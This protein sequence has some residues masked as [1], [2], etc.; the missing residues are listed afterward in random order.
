MS[1]ETMSQAEYDHHVS[2]VWKT[3]GILAVVTIIEVV[4][5]LVY[6]ES[7]PRMALNLFFIVM[8]LLKAFYI[9]AIFMHMK[10]EKP[11]LMLTVILPTTFLIWGII[12][13]L[14]EGDYWLYM[15]EFWH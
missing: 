7:F 8:S 2:A 4:G 13:F 15:R 3:T 5:A 6:P 12:A 14:W 10:Y 11:A 1:S 9:V